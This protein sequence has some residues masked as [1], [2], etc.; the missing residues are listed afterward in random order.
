MSG[1]GT[2]VLSTIVAEKNRGDKDAAVLG[3]RMTPRNSTPAK[4]HHPE[5][6]AAIDTTN[7]AYGGALALFA[8]GA[9]PAPVRL[10]VL[11]GIL[12]ERGLRLTTKPLQER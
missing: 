8:N 4:R 6:W 2:S 10:V 7:P 5:S 9:T 1:D 12:R 11:L 3:V